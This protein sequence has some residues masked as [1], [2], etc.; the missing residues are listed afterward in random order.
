[1]NTTGL[2]SS[3]PFC[4]EHSS[5]RYTQ[6]LLPTLPKSLP[7][8]TLLKQ[9]GLSVASFDYCKQDCS[10]LFQVPPYQG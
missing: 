4:Q 1:M 5:T 9:Q 3:C 8:K 7:L 6:G 2:C 10:S